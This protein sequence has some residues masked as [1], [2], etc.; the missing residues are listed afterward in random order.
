MGMYSRLIG[1]GNGLYLQTCKRVRACLRARV[2]ACMCTCV[3]L[4]VYVCVEGR[5]MHAVCISYSIQKENNLGIWNTYH[6]PFACTIGN[7]SVLCLDIYA[8][9]STRMSTHSHAHTYTFFV[10]R[11]SNASFI[12]LSESVMACSFILYFVLH[13]GCYM[14]WFI[15]WRPSHL[16]PRL[17][18]T[19][20]VYGSHTHLSILLLVQP[21]QPIMVIVSLWLNLVDM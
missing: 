10:V 5:C 19:E 15:M 4:C 6:I 21:I 12:F 20:S 11:L 16:L 14:L 9:I 2:R 7:M 13:R 1:P 3:F 17:H 18:Y 8:D